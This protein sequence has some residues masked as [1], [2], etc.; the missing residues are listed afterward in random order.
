MQVLREL[1]MTKALLTGKAAVAW[2][3]HYIPFSSP[4]QLCGQKNYLTA[5]SCTHQLCFDCLNSYRSMQSCPICHTAHEL[6]KCM[7]QIVRDTYKRAYSSWRR[8]ACHGSTSIERAFV[9][10][11]TLRRTRSMPHLSFGVQKKRARHVF[12]RIDISPDSTT[13]LDF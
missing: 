7:L 5:L 13:S 11:T 10:M 8:G 6:D 3:R 12:H 2:S 1:N 9:P 4:C